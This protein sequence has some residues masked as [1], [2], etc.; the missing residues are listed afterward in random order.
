M[1]TTIVCGKAPTGKVSLDTCLAV[2]FGSAVVSKNGIVVI[3]CE[4]IVRRTGRMV[5]LAHVE[6]QA[7]AE[8]GEW[9]AH[10][11]APFYEIE[12]RREGPRRW[13]ATKL[14]DGFA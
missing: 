14:G 13:V 5:T 2:G 3:D 7:A 11:V 1:S 12:C 4:A 10:V 8:P 9:R 6:H